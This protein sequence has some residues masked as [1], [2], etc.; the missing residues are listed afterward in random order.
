MHECLGGRRC[1]GKNRPPINNP[2]MRK[3][4]ASLT[5]ALG[6]GLIHRKVFHRK[7]YALATGDQFGFD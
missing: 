3:T 7:Q 4:Q 1:R 6:V 5:A 2:V